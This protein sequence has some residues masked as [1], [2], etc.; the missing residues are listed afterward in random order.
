[1]EQDA[2]SKIWS[3]LTPAAQG[4]SRI[5]TWNSTTE[6]VVAMSEI[7][8]LKSY[9]GTFPTALMAD[10]VSRGTIQKSDLWVLLKDGK[11]DSAEYQ[12]FAQQ[13]AFNKIH[14]ITCV[15]MIFG[16]KSQTPSKCDIS[17]GV[18]IFATVPDC[19][20]LYSDLSGIVHLMQCSGRFTQ[21][22]ELQRKPQPVLNSK[23]RWSDLPN[24]Q[25]Q[26]LANVSIPAPQRLGR[27]EIALQNG[28][29]INLEELWSGRN[30][31]EEIIDC[32]FEH[33]GNLRSI[34]LTSQT[35][36]RVE[37]FQNWLKPFLEPGNAVSLEEGEVMTS[38]KA[39]LQEMKT[40]ISEER[41]AEL[42]EKFSITHDEYTTF[43]EARMSRENER[44]TTSRSAMARLSKLPS[45][46]QAIS[47]LRDD[48]II[49]SDE[50]SFDLIS[51][52]H[53]GGKE[54]TSTESY[55]V[56][57]ENSVS[58]TASRD[59][60]AYHPLRRLPSNQGGR[61]GRS[62]NGS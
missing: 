26:K 59:A 13:I 8:S 29:V 36:N 62:G 6:A 11:I 41:R 34:M 1:M 17:V 57:G 39:M 52:W 45:R 2:V 4:H 32:I 14:G 23:T 48:S 31:S 30:L 40:E 7:Q 38:I 22:L 33:D 24:V 54:S 37:E 3:L 51:D 18:S 12:K 9:G 15:I 53:A 46:G 49:E 58:Q 16:D 19:L 55:V 21:I 28:S 10:R 47:T 5:I 42:E 56:F 44:S 27:D 35:R 25:L 61:S 43:R 50:E 60:E 20:F